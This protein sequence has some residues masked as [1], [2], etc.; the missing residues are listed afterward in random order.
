MFFA[1]HI[2]GLRFDPQINEKPPEGMLLL[3]V[4]TLYVGQIWVVYMGRVLLA[5]LKGGC[6][7]FFIVMRICL[8][9]GFSKRYTYFC[10]LLIIIEFFLFNLYIIKYKLLDNIRG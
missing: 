3:P 5:S 8:V 1:A 9:L 10:V 7:I 6:I 2:S 4:M